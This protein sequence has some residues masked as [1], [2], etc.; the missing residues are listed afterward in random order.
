[1]SR[2]YSLA[3]LTAHGLDAA[4]SVSL[5]AKLGYNAVGLRILPAAPGGKFSPLIDS[6]AMLRETVKRIADTGLR[7]LDVEIV[8]IGADFNLSAFEGFLDVCA[9]VG[10]K[11]ILVAG[12]DPD[13]AR[14]THSFAAFCAAAAKRNISADLEFM[15]WTGVKD[16]KTALRIVEDASQ[17][18]GGVLVDAL[19]W[20]RSQSSLADVK[21]I[22][23]ALLN[24][25]QIC[26]GTVP[27]PASEA[28]LVFD[29]RCNRLQPGAGG[30]DL[31]SLFSVLPPDLPISVEVPN[32]ALM[33]K[34]GLEGWARQSLAMAKA[35]IARAE[36]LA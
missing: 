15:P 1:M 36:S 25:A 13:V 28:D 8:R 20:G 4:D 14:V 24:Y 35:V 3:Y 32:D 22:P 26:D 33:P 30:I 16:C 23:R 19:H 29:A 2:I 7:V 17:P 12:D 10:A 11:A 18:N 21:A 34:L 9:A 5:A 6:Q 31:V 27:T